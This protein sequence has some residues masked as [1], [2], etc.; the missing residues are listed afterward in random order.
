MEDAPGTMD[1]TEADARPDGA[2]PDDVP[3]RN[4]RRPRRG[5][6]ALRLAVRALL[7]LV[8]LVVVPAGAAWLRLTSAPFALPEAVA[9][10]I[11]ARLDAGMTASD[12]SI[13]RM[14][15][16]LPEGGRA[17]VLEFRDVRLSDPN[18][19]PRAAFP[20]V[21]VQ[22]EAAPLL[23]GQVRPRRVEIAGAGL[24]LSR[25]GQ[26]RLDLDLSGAAGPATVTLPDTMARLD[27]MFA[28]PV[29]AGLQEV[30]ASG[31]QLSMTDEMTGQI[32]RI[33]DA[34][35]RLT[36][37]GGRLALTVGGAL[38]GSRETLVDIAVLRTGAENQ[39]EIATVFS[40]LAARDLATASPAL[41]WLDLMRA[42]ISGRLALRLA[43]DG[44]VGDLEA[45]LDIG[46][47][48]VRLSEEDTPL[49]FER[50]RAE[51]AYDPGTRRIAFMRFGV[52]APALRFE[53]QGHADV[54]EDGTSFVSQFALSGIEVRPGDLYDGTLAL[55]G[56][57]VD[58]RLTLAPAIR[59]ELGEAVVTDGD[60]RLRARGTAE[61][62]AEGLTLSLDA[63]V[64]EAEVAEILSFWPVAA[65]P[66]TR[67]WIAEN[68]EAGRAIGADF[69][70]RAAPGEPMRRH[71]QLGFE[72]L[73]MRPLRE[74]PAVRDASGY[75]EL[76]G[77]RLVV[78]M[79]AGVMEAPGGGGVAVG[80]TTMVVEDTSVRGAEAALRIEA[81]GA[82]ADVLG[83][84]DGPPFR[85]FRDGDLTAA[86]IGTGEVALTAELRP[87]LMRRNTPATLEELALN[88]SA[89]VTGFASETLVP[90][91][92]LEAERLEVFLTPDLIRVGGTA[93][94]EG[95]PA[96]GTWSRPLGP[97]A[98][99]ASTLDATA[100]LDR[101]TLAR[102][103]VTLPDWLL[104]GRGEAD[105]RLDLA[106]GEPAR[107]TATSDLAGVALAIPALGWRSGEGATGQLRA[108]MRLGP[109]PEV[110]ALG[111]AAS[112]LELDGRA[113]LAPGGG[114]ARL[115]ADRLRVGD[116][117]DVSGVLVGRRAGT[118][119][120]VE[121][122]G[123]R[124]S[125]P[126]APSLGGGDGRDSGLLSVRLDR[127]EIARGLALTGLTGAFTT[128]GGPAGDFEAAVN[129]EAP[130]SGLVVPGT[131][132]PDVRVLSAD[133]GAVLRAAGIF[134]TAHGG[135][136]TLTLQSA[137]APRSFDGAL[138]VEGPRLRD[139]PAMA[140]LL[141]LISVVGLLE[142][143]SGEGINLGTVEARFALTPE[144]LT[145]AEGTAVGPSLGI[146]MD[147][148]YDI[149]S[150]RY[151]M[152][153]VVS[154]LYMVNGLV[155]ALFAPRREGL[156]GFT[157][158][159]T[160]TAEQANVSVNPLSI[161]T[162]GIFR[163][164]FRRPPPDLTQM[165][166]N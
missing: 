9:S 126:G 139:A 21:R 141:N 158:R 150:R 70:L 59:I 74:G 29:F 57:S 94:F 23:S 46:P 147:G 17:P 48:R 11:E 127:F 160:G 6:R 60:V 112:G 104:S 92:R 19:A 75:V 124:V 47:G 159:L 73:A 100:A 133:G 66:E 134:R 99:R 56:A 43:D 106:D 132:G 40:N 113:T 67:R 111:L 20:A 35:A 34:T 152:Q 82:L 39:T 55:E 30:T 26:G 36:R 52:D 62:G 102:L 130:I 86:R 145:L 156:F 45:R 129:G 154:P 165:P 13:G 105:L 97:D 10:R 71:L 93:T 137:A 101:T 122:T 78:R 37:S 135:R 89:V 162:P 136:M 41:A 157:Y 79:D 77:E 4:E 24:R 27:A 69:A 65:I 1:G 8:L 125:L 164:I 121:I 32:I 14:V 107:L 83:V 25:D 149:A 114:L 38:S 18:G 88:A 76:A 44:T 87:R 49:G 16:D 85:I 72:D 68:I 148:I 58:M 15:I 12:L 120:D 28:A 146:S 153:G 31:L 91:R 163:E 5:R 84:L 118:P 51:L 161:L 95:V 33:E 53:G 166:A 123:G 138:R 7:V 155:G 108:E 90:E 80:G 2:R 131:F 116:W 96:T 64:A 63:S 115:T 143:L 151:E 140:E 109:S 98:P 61:A 3:K 142:Q 119:P 22:L 81:A 50:L 128:S 103:G 117:L 54:S 110:T 42:P 144:R